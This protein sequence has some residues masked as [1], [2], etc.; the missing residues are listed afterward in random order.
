VELILKQVRNSAVVVVLLLKRYLPSL[1]GDNVSRTTSDHK[2]QLHTPSMLGA[3]HSFVS[4]ILLVWLVLYLNQQARV[5]HYGIGFINNVYWSYI[6]F[7]LPL[8]ALIIWQFIFAGIFLFTTIRLPAVRTISNSMK[9]ILNLVFGVLLFTVV[10]IVNAQM[11]VTSEGFASNLWGSAF[12]V[13]LPIFIF[14]GV[15][16]FLFVFHLLSVD[17]NKSSYPVQLL[18]FLIGLGYLLELGALLFI[19]FLYN[20]F[21]NAETRV[22]FQT[23]LANNFGFIEIAL[24]FIIIIKVFQG[25][26]FSITSVK[27]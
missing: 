22:E 23:R 8:I 10:F 7:L 20:S 1:Q 13:V 15:L 25:I 24:M 16:L 6:W 9:S 27:R 4:V 2:M 5:S 18:Q 17:W 26:F 11:S 12:W 21:G 14:S 3:I 19:G